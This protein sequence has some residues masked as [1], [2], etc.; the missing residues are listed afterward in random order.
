MILFKAFFS[1]LFWQYRKFFLFL[2]LIYFL[3]Y[4]GPFHFHFHS[5]CLPSCHS[6]YA[7]TP[8]PPQLMPTMSITDSPV[9]A[10]PCP[11]G[12][13]LQHSSLPTP[14]TA[15][16][17]SPHVPETIVSK[18]FYVPPLY[19]HRNDPGLWK[20]AFR[21]KQSLTACFQHIEW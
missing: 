14:L 5:F 9:S 18:E 13:Q 16:M 8:V 17:S 12:L 10:R 4:L 15:T 7:Y 21:H 3:L 6:D 19:G 2:N 20:S 1:T 11:V